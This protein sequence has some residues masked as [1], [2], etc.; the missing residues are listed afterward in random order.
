MKLSEH[1][2]DIVY[3]PGD[4]NVNADGLSRQAWSVEIQ[5]DNTLQFAE[6]SKDLHVGECGARKRPQNIIASHPQMTGR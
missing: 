5:P 6:A 2:F 1:N 3:R 4:L